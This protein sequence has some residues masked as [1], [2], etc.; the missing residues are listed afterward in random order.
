LCGIE[1]FGQIARPLL[2]SSYGRKKRHQ[3]GA[4]RRSAVLSNSVDLVI[5]ALQSAGSN[6]PSTR[7][8]QAPGHTSCVEHT[9]R[10][11]RQFCQKAPKKCGL[12]SL[13]GA[14]IGPDIKIA[15]VHPRFIGGSTR[16]CPACVPSPRTPIS[17]A[18]ME[19]ML[20]WICASRPAG[21]KLA[22]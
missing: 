15:R 22:S 8:D 14:A 4:A 9:D 6:N 10:G 12:S 16:P 18:C 17:T 11:C 20:K 13:V 3:I 7:L 5:A 19:M 2:P 1:P 21:D